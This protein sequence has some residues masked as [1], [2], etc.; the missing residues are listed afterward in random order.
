MRLPLALS[1]VL[2]VSAVP[3]FAGSPISILA[4]ENFYGNIAEAIGGPEVT[5]KSILNN[6][7]QDPHLF[8][9]SA[10]VARALADATIVI[11]NG[12]D[13][14]PWVAKMLAAS[15][16]K[17]RT[18]ITVADLVHKQPGDNPHLW[19]DPA[20]MPAVA[21]AIAAKLAEIDPGHKADYDARLATV[22]A[23][24]KAVADKVAKIKGKHAGVPVTA[25][26]PVFG[27][28]AE[29]L[30]LTMRNERF[31]LSVMNDTEPSARDTA[32]FENDLKQHRVK[33][34]FYNSQVTDPQ[35]DRLRKLAHDGNVPVVGV[36]ETE[37]AGK[38]YAEWMLDQLDATEKAL[39]G[40]S[41]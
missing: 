3:A 32:A 19:Y 13:Y 37:P 41:S 28:M 1:V 36:S 35:V 33:A 4:A 29:A 40:P 27:Y 18:V 6:P 23:S 26:E 20:T 11:M 21:K 17:D 22:E 2:L 30:G 16:G 38:S 8:E 12:A 31:Q 39:A 14:D 7:D 5:V 10:S 34:L 9:A 15:A 24:L 25:T